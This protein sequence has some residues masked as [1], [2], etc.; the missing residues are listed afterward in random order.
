MYVKVLS[1][2]IVI[3]LDIQGGRMRVSR[4]EI[5]GKKT[6]A[7]LERQGEKILPNKV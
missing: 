7:K 2:A 4:R 5:R 3:F 6:E 1:D